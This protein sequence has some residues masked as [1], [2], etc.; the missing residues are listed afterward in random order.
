MINAIVGQSGGPTA[1]INASLSGVIKA[2][3]DCGKIDNLYGA[4]F[5]IQGVFDEH[6]C[7]LFELVPD[8]HTHA[9]LENTPASALGSCRKKLPKPEKGGDGEETYKKIFEIFEKHSIKYFFYIGGN[10]SMDTVHKLSVWAKLIGSDIKF[11]GVP[12]TI[13]NDLSLT[14]HTPGFG[15]AA[16]YIASSCAEMIRDTEVYTTDAVTI[17]E[18]MG[19]DAGW[20]TAC[21]ALARIVD[22]TA[23]DLVYLPEV[24]FDEDEFLSSVKKLFDK[25]HNVVVAV[26]EGIRNKDGVYVGESSQSGK[27][28]AFG[29]K[30]LSGTGKTLEE[31]VREKIGCKVRSVELNILQ[32]CAS[33]LASKTDIEE[34]VKVGEFAVKLALEGKTGYMASFE[35]L[36][37]KPYNCVC[38]EAD[39]SRVANV[40]RCVPS[41]FITPEKN[42][43]T[44]EC[45]EWILPLVQGETSPEYK[46]GLPVHFIIKK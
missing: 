25:K 29:H 16:K 41:E 35:R 4:L 40:V 3:R 17:F 26:S 28:D 1:A 10:D 42:N 39:L 5:G 44:D 2:C 31:L 14:D 34:S 18:I 23:P 9:L 21:S 8:E 24:P 32:R 13:D 37:T 15:S 19:R 36:S 12:K 27:V 33:H 43:V 38:A 20:L 46:N 30:Y 7:N 45:L 6:F 22:G 11:I